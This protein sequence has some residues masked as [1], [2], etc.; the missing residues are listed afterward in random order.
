[1]QKSANN[2]LIPQ[3]SSL[4]NKLYIN[5]SVCVTFKRE[6]VTN[7]QINFHNYDIN[8]NYVPRPNNC[9]HKIIDSFK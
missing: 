1:M 6:A 9:G 8:K 3:F 7:R 5:L 4:N 2:S